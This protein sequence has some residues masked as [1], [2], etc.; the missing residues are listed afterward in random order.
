M[1]TIKELSIIIP[2]YNVE[3]YIRSCLDSV[4]RQNI[5][6]NRF[7]VV[8]IDD[9]SPD[10]S[11]FIVEE[12]AKDKDNIIIISQKNKGLG[13]ARNRGIEQAQGKYLLFLDSDDYYLDNTLGMLINQC[14]QLSVDVLE[15]GAQGINEDGR[16]TYSKIFENSCIYSG[17]DYYSKTNCMDS[18]CNKIYLREFLISHNLFFLERIYIE[19]YEFNTRVFLKAKRFASTSLLV[20]C[21]FQN[22]SSIT[23]NTDRSKR[24]K[25]RSDLITVMEH[26]KSLT[27]D[28]DDK[29]SISLIEERLTFL[30]VSLF[31]QLFKDK[32]KLSE[33]KEM[34]NK[35]YELDLIYLNHPLKNKKK[36]LFRSVFLILTKLKVI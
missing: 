27:Y 6:H 11:R 7:E 4:Y 9:E 31:Y 35:L 26:I 18:A 2:I 32:C 34:K 12:Y 1:D 14:I 16:I 10:N 19:D 25:L 15:F 24:L 3:K 30:N 13:G 23:R 5:D 22:Q 28:F 29:R 33:Y 20:A 36:N 17:V 8:I 21:F